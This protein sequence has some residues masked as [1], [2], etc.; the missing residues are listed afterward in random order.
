MGPPLGSSG[1]SQEIE[2]EVEETP[3]ALSDN[4]A[5][6]SGGRETDRRDERKEGGNEGGN[7]EGRGKE[8]GNEGEGERGEMK[9]GGRK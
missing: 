7:N 9:E 3:S 5:V 8:G 4:T 6:E 1:T 2:I